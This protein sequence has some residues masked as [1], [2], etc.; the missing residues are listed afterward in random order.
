[1]P[2]G[3]ILTTVA[4]VI[5]TTYTGFGGAIT[6]YVP[7]VLTNQINTR[8]S[9]Y[10]GT[11]T[12]NG[13][14][15]WSCGGA[16]LMTGCVA[17]NVTILEPNN[18]PNLTTLIAP[19]VV[20]LVASDC[21]LTAKSIG[22]ILYAAYVGNRA[23]VNFNFSGGTNAVQSAVDAYLQATYSLTFDTIGNGLIASGG[24]IIL[25]S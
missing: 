5:D 18:S 10:V 19:K 11:V 8:Q 4:G 2:D 9:G 13:T 1:L 20:N 24:T 21:A 12:Y 22:D 17:P 23:N 15:A 14:N 6:Y 7:K 3:S 16:V 25:N